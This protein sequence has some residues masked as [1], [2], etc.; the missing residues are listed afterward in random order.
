MGKC[1]RLGLVALLTVLSVGTASSR[2]ECSKCKVVDC[3]N[4][5]QCGYRCTC[6]KLNGKIKGQCVEQ[7]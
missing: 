2:G 1:I 6:V 5:Y 3:S 4:E 7:W